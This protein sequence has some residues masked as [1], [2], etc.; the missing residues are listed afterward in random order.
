MSELDKEISVYQNELTISGFVRLINVDKHTIPSELIH[1][2]CVYCSYHI[3]NE[4]TEINYGQ[5]L[6][7]P[8]LVIKK[9]ITCHEYGDG[10]EDRTEHY[11]YGYQITHFKQS[12][13]SGGTI[14]IFGDIIHNHQNGKIISSE[15]G[16]ENGP[17]KAPVYGP[18]YRTSN[19]SS[20][21][22]MGGRMIAD[23][24][25]GEIFSSNCSHIYADKNGKK[26][27]NLSENA[28][29]NEHGTYTR[30]ILESGALYGDKTLNMLFHG[31]GMHYL[32]RGDSHRG[33]GTIIIYCNIFI[34]HGL[35]ESNGDLGCSGGSILIV[36]NKFYNFG[37][38]YAQGGEANISGKRGETGYGG[39]GRIAIYCNFYENNGNIKP[40]PYRNSRD[41]AK[42]SRI[43]Q[44]IRCQYHIQ[45]Q[46]TNNICSEEY[47]MYKRKCISCHVFTNYDRPC[48][49][50]NAYFCNDGCCGFGKECIQCIQ[51]QN[52][53]IV[54]NTTI[55]FILE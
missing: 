9:T 23:F 43:E 37:Q 22:T 10:Y 31:S 32:R 25:Y 12:L 33:G 52:K 47:K 20:Y 41:C 54:I 16:Y 55:P 27:H 36:C 50:C 4:N 51:K 39:S 48:I 53:K 17:G 18:D 5:I 24:A 34:N 7:K 11:F 38:I 44:A 26:S 21:A 49:H 30:K 1:L 42:Y 19:G 40:V 28:S 14:P 45:K 46:G 8:F 3:L 29:T 2:M 13:R 6:S 35:V 15:K